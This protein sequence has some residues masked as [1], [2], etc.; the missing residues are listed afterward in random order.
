MQVTVPLLEVSGDTLVATGEYRRYTFKL[1]TLPS[2]AVASSWTS[3][4]IT[5]SPSWANPLWELLARDYQSENEQ[6]LAL[7]SLVLASLPQIPVSDVS[8]HEALHPE[9]ERLLDAYFR[10]LWRFL[11]R[12]FQW[13]W[14]LV[15]VLLWWAWDRR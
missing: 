12:R 7:L 15:R 6:I 11:L 2:G 9:D 1:L 3:V 14:K 8:L 10:A 4:Q 5:F 13:M